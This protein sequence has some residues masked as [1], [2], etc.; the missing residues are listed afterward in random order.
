MEQTEN[1]EFKEGLGLAR[2]F[3]VLSSF[4][5]LFILWAI[6]GTSLFPDK[7][8]VVACLILAI[9]PTGILAYKLV[10]ARKRKITRSVVIGR[11]EDHG[12]RVLIYLIAML[13]P[14]YGQDM[15]TYRE[16]LAVVAGLLLILFLFWYL[17]YH[18]NNVVSVVLGFRILNVFS[19]ELDGSRTVM[20]SFILITRQSSLSSGQKIPVYRLT[21]TVYL[22]RK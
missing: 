19:P 21:N 13:L 4:S 20:P 9:F 3:M 15:S 22:E 18:Y 7:Y 14:F 17:N 16:F 11:I 6:R 5:P 8:F 2:F 1:V 10:I 12:E